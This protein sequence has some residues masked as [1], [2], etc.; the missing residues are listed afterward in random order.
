MGKYLKFI[1]IPAK[2]IPNTVSL[3]YALAYWMKL[4][5]N[6]LSNTITQSAGQNYI[7]VCL[8]KL[9]F[10]LYSKPIYNTKRHNKMDKCIFKIADQNY[11]QDCWTKLYQ[12]MMASAL[13]KI[14]E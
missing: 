9:Y 10:R 1:L 7:K 4:S 14:D 8:P 2:T 12:Y 5:V 13:I 3:K 6:I 11:S